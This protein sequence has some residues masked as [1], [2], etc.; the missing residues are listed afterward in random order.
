MFLIHLNV[1]QFQ[2]R[3]GPE[4]LQGQ[5]EQIPT[6]FYC[7]IPHAMTW[8]KPFPENDLEDDSSGIA[9]PLQ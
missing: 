7:K 6:Q 5:V 2:H 3:W 4:L 8:D 1:V 9:K